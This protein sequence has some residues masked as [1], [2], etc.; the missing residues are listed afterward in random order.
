MAETRAADRA[1]GPRR[2]LPPLLSTVPA[3]VQRGVNGK[4]RE[5]RR[6]KGTEDNDQGGT[7]CTPKTRVA[8]DAAFFKLYDEKDAVCCTRPAS[9][10]EPRGPQERVQ[11]HTVEQIADCAPVVQ[12]LNIPVPS[13]VLG[14]VQDQIVQRIVE[15]AFVDDT[16]QEIAVPKISSPARSPP[17]GVLPS[18]Q[19][20]EQLVDV[21]VPSF[22]ECSLVQVK[23]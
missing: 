8:R 19:M 10:A 2:N 13:V 18:T 22:H 6:R 11:R 14:G 3:E 9:L 1:H 16:E 20:V 17:R 15:L 23:Q 4:A 21:P 12:I 7:Y 5:A